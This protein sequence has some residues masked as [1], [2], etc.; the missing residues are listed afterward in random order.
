MS[1]DGGASVRCGSMKS[2][3]GGALVWYG[4]SY[5]LPFVC[6]VVL[7]WWTAICSQGCRVPSE[8]LVRWFTGPTAATSSGVVIS[9]ER[10]RGLPSPFLGELLWVKTTSF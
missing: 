3:D 9:L 10:C 8:S 5:V 1:A 2:A 7:S 4:G 6:V